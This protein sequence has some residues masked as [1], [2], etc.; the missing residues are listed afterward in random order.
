[1]K[2]V[3]NIMN[4]I[5]D[6]SVKT[7]DGGEKSLSDYHGKV[8]LIVNTASKCGLTPQL[9][10]M[11]S[12]YETFKG[13]DFEI[14]AFPSNNFAGQEPL[15]GKAIEEFCS[16]EYR[17]S[18]PIFEKIDVIGESRNPLYAFL[19]SKKLN[20]KVNVS[21]KWNFQKYLVNKQGEVVD[22]FLPITSP[23]SSSV[24]KKIEK[25]IAL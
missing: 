16:L 4:T 17:A 2:I 24:I 12:L 15:E 19:S 20:G 9:K 14:L 7:L 11:Q 1:M 5:Y 13:Q 6:F 21:P 8:L 10:E 22:Y 18:F 3:S 25:L 23:T